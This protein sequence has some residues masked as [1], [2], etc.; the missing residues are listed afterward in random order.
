M[1]L[2]KH[3]LLNRNTVKLSYRCLPNM[4]AIISA[5]NQ[6]LLKEEN[7]INKDSGCN[8]RNKAECPLE[9]R[10]LTNKVVYQA[11]VN[12]EDD[13]KTESYVG[14]TG[15]TFKQRWLQ[16]K[17]SFKLEHKQSATTLSQ[18]IWN[19]RR[20]G[21]KFKINWKI[22]RRA[23]TFSPVTGKCNLCTSEKFIFLYKNDLGSLNT[24]EEL[25]AK[26]MHMEP[27]LLDKT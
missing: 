12:T 15:N 10:C 24:R 3:K 22:L 8:C 9:G 25:T 5:H 19:F 23:N 13:N 7:E 14:I 27:L 18:H 2:L 16:H 21:K 11:T 1:K 20:T 17:S 26:C 4:N 6:K